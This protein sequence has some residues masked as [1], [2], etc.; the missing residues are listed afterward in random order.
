MQNQNLSKIKSDRTVDDLFSITERQDEDQAHLLTPKKS[1]RN[2]GEC[3]E[4]MFIHVIFYY[5]FVFQQDNSLLRES[6]P[7][8]SIVQIKR[9]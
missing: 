3:K 4:N 7:L 1:F 5:Y 9:I 8:G 6:L 2:I